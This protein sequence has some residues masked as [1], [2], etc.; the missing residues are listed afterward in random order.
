M[1]RGGVHSLKR[2]GGLSIVEF[3]RNAEGG[4]PMVSSTK[5][6]T[7]RRKEKKLESEILRRLRAIA[8]TKSMLPPFYFVSLTLSPLRLCAFA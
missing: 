8:T 2:P 3:S 5:N 7:Q 4:V 6:L 1:R